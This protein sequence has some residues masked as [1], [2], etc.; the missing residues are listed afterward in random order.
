MNSVNSRDQLVFYSAKTLSRV[1]YLIFCGHAE[2]TGADAQRQN[3]G[4]GSED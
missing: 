4:E 1:K 2:L 3:A